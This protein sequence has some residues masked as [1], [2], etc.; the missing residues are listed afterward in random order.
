MAIID[1]MK[2]L[3]QKLG[4]K[5]QAGKKALT[6]E[7]Y[8]EAVFQFKKAIKIA[9]QHSPALDNIIGLSYSYLALALLR[10]GELEESKSCLKK[11]EV[12]FRTRPTQAQVY[13]VILLDIGLKFQKN[14]LFEESIVLMKIAL[15]L[16]REEK[17]TDNLEAISIISRNLAYSYFKTGMNTT[18]A[19]LFR[20]SADLEEKADVAVELYQNAAYLYYKE[21][22]KEEALNILETAFNRLN[23]P[24]IGS[25][26]PNADKNIKEIAKFQ[27]NI[28]YEIF[29]KLQRKNDLDQALQCLELC[30]DKSLRIENNN[31][32]VKVLYEQA[33]I[34]QKVGN[35]SQ[36]NRI[37]EKLITAESNVNTELYIAKASLILITEAL[38]K[39]NWNK[40]E[41]YLTI[42]SNIPSDK[43]DPLI[44]EKIKKITDIVEKSRQRKQIHTNIHFTLKDLDLPLNDLIAEVGNYSKRRTQESIE[45]LKLEGSST[46]MSVE[47]KAEYS[48]FGTNFKPP[49]IEILNSLFKQKPDKAVHLKKSEK[50]PDVRKT[51]ETISKKTPE[52]KHIEAYEIFRSHRKQASMN[53]TSKHEEQINLASST[54]AIDTNE[55][56]NQQL[57]IPGQ[58]CKQLQ[59]AGWTVRMNLTSGQQRGAEPDI[60]SEKG[61]IRKKKKLIFFAEDPTDAEIC[62]FLLQSNLDEGEKIVYLLSGDPREVNV[63]RKVKV[64]T[65]IDQIL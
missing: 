19:K 32:M 20:I 35:Y 55:E 17:S 23:I 7:K 45:G 37:L 9:S 28:A 33:M 3:R 63:S 39:K 58:V 16:V 51:I 59:K 57:S 49:S 27:A 34:Q 30:Y 26:V 38:E 21:E 50:K 42:L 64:V 15:N 13:A 48:T 25:H 43:L 11:I 44:I 6:E 46:L 47:P 29:R 52:K 61:L 10:K 5:I 31:L 60:I 53:T 12:Y 1:T 2:E 62:G 14:N 8:N 36:R 22:F 56:T 40:V 4:A 65:G 24:E 18:A 54:I 41:D